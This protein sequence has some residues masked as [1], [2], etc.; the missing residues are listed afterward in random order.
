MIKESIKI[1]NVGPLN[2]AFIPDLKQLTILIGASASG[3]S[4]LMKIIVLMRYIFKRV[5]VKA[6][7]KNSNIDGAIFYIRFSDLLKNGLDEMI[8]KES[9]IEYSVKINGTSYQISYSN[10]K[11]STP[12]SIRNE[13]LVFFKESWISDMRS[14]IPLW[15]S[16]GALAKGS[17]LGFYFDETFRDFDKATD[18][19][20]Q[21]DLSYLG[22][23]MTV[24]KGGNNQKKFTIRAKDGQFGSIDLKNASSG[25]QTTAPLY[26][27]V[28]YFATDFSFKDAIRNSIIMTLFEKG[29]TEKYHPGIEVGDLPKYIHI[30][31]E[32]PELSLDPQ[33]QRKLVDQ[34]CDIIFRNHSKD[35]HMNLL[36]ATHSPYVVNQLN[37]VIKREVNLCSNNIAVYHLHEGKLN[38]LVMSDVESGDRFI[39]SSALSEPITDI[40]EEYEKFNGK[41]AEK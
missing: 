17:N 28:K 35:R 9:I 23:D 25:T 40:Y 24:T 18:A 2:N 38:D 15:A 34:L 3:K 10:G 13:D 5:T 30:H 37:L 22:M 12:K 11:L 20:K 36:M 8:S 21:F 4:T 7:L 1:E 31:A 41:F 29:L 6:Y 32:E 16:R 39:D 14:A 27:I 19:S 26:A 33:S